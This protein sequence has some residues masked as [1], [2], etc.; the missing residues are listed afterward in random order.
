[1][2]LTKSWNVKNA[3]FGLISIWFCPPLLSMHIQGDLNLNKSFSF[4]ILFLTSENTLKFLPIPFFLPVIIAICITV[5]E[6]RWVPIL[7]WCSWITYITVTLHLT[8]EISELVGGE[9]QGGLQTKNKDS[10]SNHYHFTIAPVRCCSER[11]F[12]TQMPWMRVIPASY[13]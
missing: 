4:C 13:L 6:C 11:K 5:W 7:T 1:M 2:K 10:N 8:K 9:R 3:T 12:D